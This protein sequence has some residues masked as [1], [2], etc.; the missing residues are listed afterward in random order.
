MAHILPSHVRLVT[1]M[2]TLVS[3]LI[4]ESPRWTDISMLIPHHILSWF[5]HRT[6][7]HSD[8]G[9][10]NRMNCYFKNDGDVLHSW[11]LK[12]ENSVITLILTPFT[13]PDGS[14][15]PMSITRWSASRKFKGAAVFYTPRKQTFFYGVWVGLS[16]LRCHT[17][18]GYQG[19]LRNLQIY[20]KTSHDSD[21][22]RFY[23]YSII[24]IW[25]KI[26]Y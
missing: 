15:N 2:M 16:P 26:I 14:I 5:K 18:L 7:K 6:L 8:N 12:Y 21:T 19:D 1:I 23:S 13:G 17:L 20:A 10:T 3:W 4:T 25:L 11:I 9:E 22:T 24:S